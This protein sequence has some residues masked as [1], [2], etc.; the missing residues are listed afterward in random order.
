MTAEAGD[1]D[2]QD[3]PEPERPPLEPAESGT[4]AR[5][6]KAV[7]ELNRRSHRWHP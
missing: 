2:D 7:Q 1:E 3:D 6:R 5:L 4:T